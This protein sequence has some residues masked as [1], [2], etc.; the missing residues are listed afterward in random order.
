MNKTDYDPIYQKRLVTFNTIFIGI[1]CLPGLFFLPLF[2]HVQITVLSL[3]YIIYKL[4]DMAYPKLINLS[5]FK[6]LGVYIFA[7][8]LAA[9]LETLISYATFI[10]FSMGFES[11]ERD[12]AI[13][14]I[15]LTL[16]AFGIIMALMIFT[17]NRFFKA[18]FFPPQNQSALH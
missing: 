17:I 9:L 16:A 13:T 14:M 6:S 15:P 5:F 2:P 11:H 8:L 1:F 4:Q 3:I 12:A 10:V 7:S 18:Y